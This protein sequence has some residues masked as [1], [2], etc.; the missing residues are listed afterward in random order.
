MVTASFN[1]ASPT[2]SA[3]PYGQTF[4]YVNLWGVGVGHTYSEHHK[5]N[6]T[7]YL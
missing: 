2:N 7:V 5:H 3:T 4:K 1:K 6:K